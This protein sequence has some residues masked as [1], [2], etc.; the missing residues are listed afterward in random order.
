MR[1]I[2]SLA[3]YTL[4]LCATSTPAQGI[5]TIQIEKVFYANA[6]SGIVTFGDGK[7]GAVPGALV[8]ECSPKWAKTIASTRTDENGSFKL[9]ITSHAS[10][11]YLRILMNGADPLLVRVKLDP[12]SHGLVLSLQ[13]ST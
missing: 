8:E 13:P 7:E 4:L 6:L 5:S 3:T 9:P 11:H 10:I 2:S 12:K 1:K